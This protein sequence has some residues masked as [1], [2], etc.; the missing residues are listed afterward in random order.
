[1][2]IYIHIPIHMCCSSL[3]LTPPGKLLAYA[4]YLAHPPCGVSARPGSGGTASVDRTVV[5][6]KRTSAQLAGKT[7]R[8]MA[9]ALRPKNCSCLS[10]LC[11]AGDFNCVAYTCTRVD[12]C[13]WWTPPT[14]LSRFQVIVPMFSCLLGSTRNR[15]L[16]HLH[17][18]GLVHNDLEGVCIVPRSAPLCSRTAL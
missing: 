3:A 12:Q 1:M 17:G 15:G 7:K 2:Y 6:R 4:G 14:F 9:A 10:L 16:L 8:R 13:A 18:V 11:S 5:E